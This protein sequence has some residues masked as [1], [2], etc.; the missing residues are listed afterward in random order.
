[1]RKSLFILF[2]F[3]LCILSCTEEYTHHADNYINELVVQ[4]LISDVPEDC[5]VQL[6]RSVDFNSQDI[7]SEK[8]AI[9]YVT[10][11]NG[12]ICEFN[13][14]KDGI[15]K[16][17]KNWKAEKNNDYFLT[18]VTKNGSEYVSE[19]VSLNSV[20]RID[21]IYAVYSEVYSFQES[22]YIKG[23]NICVDFS[24]EN[25]K[26]YF[27]RWN[28]IETIKIWQKWQ[29]LNLPNVSYDPCWQD[30]R[31]TEV[32][33]F[34]TKKAQSNSVKQ[35]TVKHL[36]EFNYQP[37]FGFSIQITQNSINKKVYNFWQMVK[38]NSEKNGS[39][40]GNI[41]YT[42]I[43][44]IECNTDHNKKVFGYFDAY[45]N[46]KK[47]LYL[48]APIFDIPFTDIN[49]GCEARTVL[50]SELNSWLLENAFFLSQYTYTLSR[51][52]VDCTAYENSTREKP[53]FWDYL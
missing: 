31:S 26:D 4:G 1:L 46:V 44:N 34:D 37:Y 22:K 35:F 8:D 10:D 36:T 2:V 7:L 27:L 12:D 19:I 3:C 45:S 50:P 21:S 51:R 48:K 39:L 14:I 16:P 18:I 29:A 33:I 25:G 49:V 28:Y 11:N 47:R 13:E 52:C 24:W 6:F 43:G 9:V 32:V 38:E 15:Y 40:Y 53:D 42:A 5:E 30:Q 17:T 20:P 23:I 41:P